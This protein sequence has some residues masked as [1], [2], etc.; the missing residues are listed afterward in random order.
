M[1]FPVLHNVVT[2]VHNN[3]TCK[4]THMIRNDIFVYCNWV[5]TRWQWS[6][7]LCKHRKEAA[8]KEKQYI[9][10]KNTEYTKQ[11]T[12]IQNKKQI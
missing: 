5:S 7:D 6:V 4:Y 1:L 8:Q 3:D 10:Y 11:K 9:K 2:I 12:K